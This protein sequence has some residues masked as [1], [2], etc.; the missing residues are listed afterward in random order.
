MKLSQGSGS[1]QKNVVPHLRPLSWGIEDFEVR[2]TAP[3][4]V[5]DPRSG[6]ALL[7]RSRFLRDGQP[8]L[9]TLPLLEELLMCFFFPCPW[10]HL[11]H[12]LHDADSPAVREDLAGVPSPSAEVQG[13]CPSGPAPLHPAAPAFPPRCC[14]DI[15]KLLPQ[16]GLPPPQLFPLTPLWPPT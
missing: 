12:G 2:E 13:G 6:G 8:L 11:P 1:E 16:P 4:D 3:P 9:P 14:L 10:R 5:N 15:L 7:R